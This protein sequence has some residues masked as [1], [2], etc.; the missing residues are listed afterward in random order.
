MSSS[1]PVDINLCSG[2]GGLALGLA[3]S[4]FGPFDFF[5]RDRGACETLRR[6]IGNRRPSLHGRVFEGDLTQLT[7]LDDFAPVRLLTAGPPCQPFS[8]GGSRKGHE[9]ERNLFPSVLEAVRVLRPRAILIE[10]VRGLARGS[11]RDY[12]D[13]VL[14]QLAYPDVLKSPEETWEDHDQRIRQHSSDKHVSP[15]Y[16]VVWAVFNAADFGVPQ[17]RYR[18]FI[19]ATAVDLPPY[20]SQDPHILGRNSVKNSARESIGRVGG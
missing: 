4:G 6:N 18:L 11:H 20:H 16:N 2:A 7:W 15:A 1:A 14:G 5:D 12:L 17:V 3:Q 10:N 13:Y 9:D 8:A 19:V